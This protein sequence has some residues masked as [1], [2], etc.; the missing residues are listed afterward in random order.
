MEELKKDMIAIVTK[1]YQTGE[2]GVALHQE[3][4][5]DYI[6]EWIQTNFIPREEANS[7]SKPLD[8]VRKAFFKKIGYKVEKIDGEEAWSVTWFNPEGYFEFFK[9]YLSDRKPLDEV[10]KEAVEGYRKYFYE[11]LYECRTDIPL[12]DDLISGNK[13]IVKFDEVKL[14]DIMDRYLSQEVSKEQKGGK[15]DGK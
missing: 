4:T 12:T 10:R 9:S 5:I 13:T 6:F 3:S 14:A 15:N 2:S 11:H 7:G 1:I 8:E